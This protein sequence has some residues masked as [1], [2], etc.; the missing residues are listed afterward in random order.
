MSRRRLIPHTTG[1]EHDYYD[2]CP[3]SWHW[4]RI[5]RYPDWRS[6]TLE[7]GWLP[8]NFNILTSRFGWV[9]VTVFCGPGAFYPTRKSAGISPPEEEVKS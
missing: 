6:G 3:S 9:P 7:H 5:H 8:D 4:C 1:F 2:T